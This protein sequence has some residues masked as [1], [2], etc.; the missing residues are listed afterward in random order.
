[1]GLDAGEAVPTHGGFRGG[2]LNVAARLCAM[3]RAGQILATDSVAHLAQ[4][5]D[6]LRFA[7][8]RSAHLKGITDRVRFVEVV[9][10]VALPSLPPAPP[11]PRRRRRLALAAAVVAGVL[12]I[13]GVLIVSRRS[14]TPRVALRPNTVAVM[15]P[16]THTVV[17]DVTV[18]DSPG[19]V[20]AGFGAV[21]VA[22][23]AD[24]TI[25]RIDARTLHPHDYG[26]PIA[27]SDLAAGP[28]H[29]YV[30]DRSDGE[31][32]ELDPSD[33]A[34]QIPFRVPRR[35]LSTVSGEC[36]N[37][38]MVFGG[39]VLWVASDPAGP[40]SIWGIDP[41]TLRRVAHLSNVFAQSLAWGFGRIWAYAPNIGEVRTVDPRSPHPH[42]YEINLADVFSS[43]QVTMT[44]DS[45]WVVSPDGQ[46]YVLSPGDTRTRSFPLAP[47]IEDATTAGGFVWITSDS[48]T[49]YEVSAASERVEH[50]YRLGHPAAGV[51]SADGRIW[52][53]LDR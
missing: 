31:G 45:A 36:L 51:A 20:V 49:M 4:R 21:W 27:P 8:G 1:M 13:G 18:G 7:G 10:D 2:S 6:G 41:A 40:P 12:I 29:I 22:N 52:V 39:G 33:P 14:G 46:I 5:V 15:S 28:G 23:T 19:S 50:R 11:G 42:R 38:G 44:P 26:V 47:G 32:V 30:Y 3:A 34:R 48:G 16:A 24:A 25:T 17:A 35:C 37:G 43:P 9:P 53:A